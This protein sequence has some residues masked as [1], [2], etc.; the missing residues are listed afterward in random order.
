MRN[1]KPTGPEDFSLTNAFSQNRTNIKNTGSPSLKVTTGNASTNA[2]SGPGPGGV[3]WGDWASAYKKSRESSAAPTAIG[4][5]TQNI[6]ATPIVGT[7]IG[8]TPTGAQS[9]TQNIGAP[10]GLSNGGLPGAANRPLQASSTSRP[11]PRSG[12]SGFQPSQAY[13][14][15]EAVT[16]ATPAYRDMMAYHSQVTAGGRRPTQAE[17]DQLM[18]MEAAL[19]NTPEYLEQARLFQSGASSAPAQQARQLS[20]GGTPGAPNF[21]LRENLGTNASGVNM[22]AN[23]ERQQQRQQEIPAG[24][25][26][27]MT[28]YLAS[29]DFQNGK[30]R[31]GRTEEQVYRD[32]IQYGADA[33]TPEERAMLR[34]VAESWLN[35]RYPTDVP[36]RNGMIDTGGPDLG[37]RS[38]SQPGNPPSNA[39][40]APPINDPNAGVVVPAP[41]SPPQP[42]TGPYPPGNNAGGGSGGGGATGGGTTGG[43]ATG[44][45]TT[46]GGVTQ[47]PSDNVPDYTTGVPANDAMGAA[48]AGAVMN[49]QVEW[50]SLTSLQQ[51]QVLE[52]ID[53][54]MADDPNF[55]ANWQGNS[56]APGRVNFI[57]DQYIARFGDPT[58][59]NR[60]SAQNTRASDGRVQGQFQPDRGAA[61]QAQASDALIM[62]ERGVSTTAGV[63]TNQQND[64]GVQGV[65]G[66]RASQQAGQ[67]V[68][69]FGGVQGEVNEG[70]QANLANAQTAADV[71]DARFATAD[72]AQAGDAGSVRVADMTAA[73]AAQQAA[74]SV[75][76][77]QGSTAG[78]MTPQQVAAANA[79]A[80]QR[81]DRTVGQ[82]ELSSQRLSDIMA[83]DGLLMQLA[84][85]DGIDFSQRQ[86]TRNSSLAAGNIAREMMRQATPLAMQEAGVYSTTGMQNQQ[87]E[88]AR[89]AANAGLEQQANLFNA[90][91][92]NTAS[93]QEFDVEAARRD[94]NATRTQQNQQFNAGQGNQMSLQQ[95]LTEAARRDANAQRAQQAAA[96]NQAAANVAA[97]EEFGVD[98]RRLEADAQRLQQV[99]LANQGAE[100]VS[101]LET[102][103]TDA[104]RAEA[105]ALR[106]QQAELANQGALNVADAELFQAEAARR[107]ADAARAQQAGLFS[108][109]QENV[110]TRQEFDAEAA[111]REANAARE[112]QA[113]MFTA[114]SENQATSQEFQTEAARRDADA[115]RLQQANIFSA[116]AQNQALSQQYQTEAATRDANA[117][118]QTQVA[119]TNAGFGNDMM[120]ADRQRDMSYNLQQ[121]AGDQ[122]YA[123]QQLAAQTSVDL[124]NIEGQYNILISDN[125]T[126]A[127]MVQSAYDAIARVVGNENVF[128][129]E[130]AEK[131]NYITNTLTS[132]LDGVLAFENFSLPTAGSSG[133][134]EGSN[135]LAGTPG[136][137]GNNW[138]SFRG[139]FDFT[140]TP[141]APGYG[142]VGGTE[143]L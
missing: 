134:G 104:Q 93:R 72:A 50:N 68:E 96:A 19:K 44:G 136:T 47:N 2:L 110:A 135:F 84:R 137:G 119:I 62:G 66:T 124:A 130:A 79:A 115:A 18:Q 140:Y 89:R 32:I 17:Q 1:G 133:Q 8:G 88:S 53:R 116:D 6:G 83:R 132:M 33:A 71:G 49:G 143:A 114:D 55:W 82:N 105:D 118:R 94:A 37:G 67:Q 120:N 28:S 92:Q 97:L 15:A 57:R 99:G 98:A 41:G 42:P 123:K 80:A 129:D 73:D 40:T 128:G 22:N 16:M 24:G 36:V 48:V 11:P 52:G 139:N 90:A 45:G 21:S 106:A 126:A 127:S 31:F 46:G 65:A 112:Q 5:S 142:P 63:T 85:Q 4:A 109:E 108:A 34:D 3:D 101:L 64:M 141:I 122:D 39:P 102:F 74:L 10:R 111:R 117:A 29:L 69:R 43:G 38:P 70:R 103:R 113:N 14:D 75:E 20:L 59:Q 100:N 61:N 27:D 77:S 125:A 107:D 13:R 54:A 58:Q 121:L 95:Y 86:G 91:E 60:G 131:V 81:N 76:R 12:T 9:S 56:D 30:D 26:T 87:L 7:P 23:V 138:D 35:E 78:Q 51:D 25:F